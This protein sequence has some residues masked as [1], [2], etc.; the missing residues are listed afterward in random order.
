MGLSDCEINIL[1]EKR[2]IE[3]TCLGVEPELYYIAKEFITGITILDIG[4]SG[5][6]QIKD[7]NNGQG[8]T[9]GFIINELWDTL[10]IPPLLASVIV[11]EFIRDTVI[12]HH[13]KINEPLGNWKFISASYKLNKFVNIDKEYNF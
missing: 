4:D 11:N 12:W 1:I 13:L 10:G 3:L 6:I 7:K 5:D 8:I 9:V 2:N